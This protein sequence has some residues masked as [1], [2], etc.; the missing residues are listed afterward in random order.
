M[1]DLSPDGETGD[2]TEGTPTWVYVFAAIAIIVI[3]LFIILLVVGG[4]GHGPGRHAL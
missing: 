3:L 1:T 2:D 4:G